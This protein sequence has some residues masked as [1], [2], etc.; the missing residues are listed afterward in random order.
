MSDFPPP[1]KVR[2]LLAEHSALRS[3]I[4]ARMGHVY[5]VMTVLVAGTAILIGLKQLV[6]WFYPLL[7]ILVVLAVVAFWY[8]NRD[9]WKAAARLREIEIDVN[10]RAGEDLL[11]WENL[12]RS[13]GYWGR[14]PILPRSKIV[15]ITKART[16]IQGRAIGENRL[17]ISAAGFATATLYDASTDFLLRED[18]KP[19]P[20]QRA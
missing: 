10:D 1:E 9:I 11:V 8:V 3:E 5:Q 16:H 4:V 19:V 13:T 2:I 20:R 14:A 18:Y 15:G 7:V 6:Q 17:A 12:W